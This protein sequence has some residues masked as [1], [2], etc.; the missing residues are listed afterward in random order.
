MPTDT[1]VEALQ[2]AQSDPSA[3]LD[4]ALLQQLAKVGQGRYFRAR[5]QRHPWDAINQVLRI[6]WSPLPRPG[7]AICRT[8]SSIPG[9]WTL[10]WLLL[11][12]PTAFV[13]TGP[14]CCACAPNCNGETPMIDRH[15]P[16]MAVMEL[17]LL[18]PLWLLAL[19]PWLWQ[20]WR[21]RKQAPLA[22]APAMGRP[23]CCRDATAPVPGSGWPVCPS[24]WL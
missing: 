7:P 13:G 17:I 1:F 3:E 21:R 4:E 9:P 5:T 15:G 12:C 20:G 11:M 6:P 8:G 24:Y 18:R 23:T 10:A 19:L 14:A 22:L 2:P 16:G